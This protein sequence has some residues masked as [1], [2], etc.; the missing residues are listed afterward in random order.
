MRPAESDD[1]PPEIRQVK[2]MLSAQ[3]LGLL[4]SL[5]RDTYT[6]QGEIVDGGAFL[7]GSTLALATGLR[8][9]PRVTA[10]NGRIHSYDLFVADA[11]APQ[12]LGDWPIGSS[13]R[14][15]YDGVIAPLAS[16]V[17]V[18]EGDITS[19]PWPAATPIEILFIDIAKS[20]AINDFLL[21]HYF[22]RLIPGVSHVI[23][24]DYHWTQ[25]PWLSI[26]MELLADHVTYLGS[27]PWA[28]AVYRWERPLEPGTLPVRLIDLGG[29]RLRSLAERAQRFERGGREWT[30]QQCNRV[31]LS[32]WLGDVESASRLYEETVA[33]APAWIEYF[34]YRP[35]LPARA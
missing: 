3:E 26:T 34:A 23:Q 32:L 17:Q 5:A 25:V 4:Y 33:D 7:G 30:A 20:W 27:M 16:L 28:T 15:Y 21:Q 24:Q 19:L 12:F 2:T 14:P 31:A 1:L 9:N 8:D 29:T 35:A 10:K 18:H 22:P 13:T 6:G 11:F